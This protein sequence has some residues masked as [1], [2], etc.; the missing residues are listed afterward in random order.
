[1]EA[2]FY[3][4]TLSSAGTRRTR[5]ESLPRSM[6]SL[7]STVRTDVSLQSLVHRRQHSAAFGNRT[8]VLAIVNHAA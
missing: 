4:L 5:S 2:V 6:G 8:E 7:G 1:M 3:R